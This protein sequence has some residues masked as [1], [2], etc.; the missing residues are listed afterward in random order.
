[1]SK[2]IKLDGITIHI[3][4]DTDPESPREWSN[5]GTMACFHSRYNLGNEQPKCSPTEFMEGLATDADSEIYDIMERVSRIDNHF[6]ESYD[7]PDRLAVQIAGAYLK[8]RIEK[9]LTDNYVMRRLFLY[10]H[11]GITMSTSSFNDIWDSG[12]VGWIY[13]TKEKVIA[14]Y[15]TW[16]AETI[17][18]IEGYLDGEVEIYDQYLRGEIYGY[19]IEDPEDEDLVIE[20]CWGFYGEDECEAEARI[21]AGKYERVECQHSDVECG[22]FN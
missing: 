3:E 6:Y 20:S 1:M 15:G 5:L 21:V 17:E 8:A 10:D 11:G 9:T 2:T 7:K 18:R 22:V 14:E 19:V 12:Q 13:V 4:Q 16:D